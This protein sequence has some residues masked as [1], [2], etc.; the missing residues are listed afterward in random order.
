MISALSNKEGP[1]DL[2]HA[3]VL[4]VNELAPLEEAAALAGMDADGFVEALGS[5]EIQS[6]IETESAKM[7]ATGSLTEIKST[8][9]LHKLV[10]QF[11][12]DI[13][14]GVPIGTAIKLAEILLRI[15]GLAEKR[16]AEARQ[17]A[18]QN[19]GGFSITIHLNGDREPLRIGGAA[20][21]EGEVMEVVDE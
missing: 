21:I 19:S 11:G 7:K 5:P 3:G 4:L 14:A 8:G 9:L 6:Q 2:I 12:A 18:L 10:C 13:E 15:S 16:A 20:A 17:G 1:A